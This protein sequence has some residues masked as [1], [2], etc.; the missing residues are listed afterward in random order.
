MPAKTLLLLLALPVVALVS[1]CNRTPE[2]GVT[3]QAAVDAEPEVSNARLQLPPPGADMAAAY[4]DVL[5]PGA[6]ALELRA[7]SSPSFATIEMHETREEGG[8]SRMRRIDQVS[9]PAG[10]SASFEPGGKHLMLM[11]SQLD[12]GK[13]AQEIPMRLSFVAADGTERVVEAH[14]AVQ[15]AGDGAVEAHH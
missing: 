6:V 13:P 3:S 15:T 7:I 8:L 11:G 1:A 2:P 9:I 10:G 14:F 5:N 4:F 12:P